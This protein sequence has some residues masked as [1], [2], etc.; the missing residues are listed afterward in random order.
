[1]LRHAGSKFKR[2]VTIKILLEVRKASNVSLE[3]KRL[4]SQ[5]EEG[6]FEVK[7]LREALDLLHQRDV[8][9]WNPQHT[10]SKLFKGAGKAL[11]CM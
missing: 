6:T 9:R 8:H 4:K 5:Q 3:F 2:A 10:G 7:G 11:A 1:M